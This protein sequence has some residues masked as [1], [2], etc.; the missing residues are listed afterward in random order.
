MALHVGEIPFGSPLDGTSW[1]DRCAELT[2]ADGLCRQIA[3]LLPEA[4]VETRRMGVVRDPVAAI[5]AALEERRQEGRPVDTLH[6]VA[7]G[8]P[9]AFRLGDRWMDTAELLAH[10]ADLARWQVRTIALWSCHLGQD[11]AVLHVLAEHTGARVWATDRS[12][13]HHHGWGLTPW[14]SADRVASSGDEVHG[15][16][17]RGP[18]DP[19]RQAEWIHSLAQAVQ[20]DKVFTG[21][22]EGNPDFADVAG[23]LLNYTITVTNIGDVPLTNIGVEDPLTG[24]STTVAGLPIGESAS[25]TDLSYILTQQDLDSNGGGDGDIDNTATANVIISLNPLEFLRDED[26]VAVPLLYRP[27]ISITKEGSVPGGTAGLD[28][29]I[30]YTISVEN[31]GNITLTNVEV[32]DPL[33]G[34]PV[35]TIE[36]LAPGASQ[37][38]T[39]TYEVTQDDIDSNG[40]GDG[41][42]DNTATADADQTG[43]VS[44]SAEVPLTPAQAS[45]TLSKSGSVPGGT[46]GLGELITYTL[47]VGNNGSQTLTNVEVTDPL[48]GG[49]VGTIASLAPG[50]SQE[51]TF[52]YEVTQDDIDSNGGGDGDID[53]TAT[54]DADQTGPVSASA[55]VPLTSAQASLTLSKSGSVPGGTA[56]LGELI[57]YTLTVGN[58]GSQ[59]LTNVEVTDPLAGGPVGTI[60]SLAPGASQ[61]LTFTYEVTQD[62]IDSNGGGDGDIDNTATADADQTGPVSASAEVPLTPPPPGQPQLVITP[63]GNGLTV[64]GPKGSSLWVELLVTG[65]VAN[66]QNTLTLVRTSDSNGGT[67]EQIL[68]AAEQGPSEISVERVGALGSTPI[69]PEVGYLGGKRYVLLKEGEELNFVQSTAQL[70]E[71][72]DPNIE[73]E[74]VLVQPVLSATPLEKILYQQDF[75]SPVGFINGGDDVSGQTVNELY[76][77]QPPGFVF[78]QQFTVETL[79]I[80]GDLAW[81]V[82]E[83]DPP[84]YKD[85]QSV[86]GSHAVSMLS[87]AQNDLLGL[88]FNT[89]DFKFLNVRLDISSIDLNTRGGPFFD[90]KASKFEFSLYDNPSGGSGLGNGTPLSTAQVS[91]VLAP[92]QWT[93]NWSDVA[94]GLSTEGN[95]N[96]NVILRIDLLEGGYAAIDNLVI[97]SSDTPASTAQ[98]RLGLDDGGGGPDD[99]FNDLVLDIKTVEDPSSQPDYIIGTPQVDATAGLFDLTQ[100]GTGGGIDLALSVSTYS[101]LSNTL[102]FVEVDVDAVTG[103][104]RVGGIDEGTTG[105]LDAVKANLESFSYTLGGEGNSGSTT[106]EDIDAGL[107][108]PVLITGNGDVLTFGASG[109][110]DGQAHLK[111]LGQNLFSFEDLLADQ[112]TDWD[113]NDF[114]LQAQVAAVPS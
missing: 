36:S 99:D 7:H 57:T 101:E 92:N 54:A 74:P 8:R 96:G 95:T 15:D 114:I 51:L 33:A 79:L 94:L 46:A 60:A 67:E 18:F 50:A 113:Y 62:D 1:T 69:A 10:A 56:G 55:E 5:S 93:F 64:V 85:P 19:L 78:A 73:I 26:S 34:G 11:A 3:E 75:E 40:G 42:I 4:P 112:G 98:Y 28:E 16:S 49:P 21:S 29:L 48:A 108:A 65:A 109:G 23:E 70:A 37:E 110:A 22:S 102:R 45:L 31:S 87:S 66:W 68:Q 83:N 30:T 77:D 14:S 100:F 12:L 84:G 41:D 38:L 89:E 17:P 104:K 44:A 103:V 81:P 6:L 2:I 35:G 20:I 32:T 86:G 90:G 13:D 52:T 91:G 58:N 76:S 53:N 71:N 111:V 59:T 106:W 88:S 72:P 27:S 82:T 39:F 63:D 25:F 47:T 61:E 9:G 43:P 105:F 80:G 97:S 24:L 107:Y